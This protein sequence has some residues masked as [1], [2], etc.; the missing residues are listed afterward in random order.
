MKDWQR[1]YF[2]L[3]AFD[4]DILKKAHGSHFGLQSNSDKNNWAVTG[5]VKVCNV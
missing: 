4:K 5:A 3:V 1:Q 2:V